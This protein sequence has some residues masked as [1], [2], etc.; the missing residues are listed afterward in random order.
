MKTLTLW[1][2]DQLLGNDRET[3]NET[4]TTAMLQLHEYATVPRATV[5]VLLEAV[6][7]CGSLQGYITRPT[8]LS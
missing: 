2:I 4:T 5:E 8:E 1:H 6:F 7:L 3:N